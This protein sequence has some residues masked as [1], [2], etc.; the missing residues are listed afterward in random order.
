[1]ASTIT[2][3][4]V[5]ID[6]TFPVPGQ[7]NDTQ[8]FRDN[9]IAIKN[10][11][12]NAAFEVT[13]LQAIQTGIINSISTL[14]TPTQISATIVTSTIV[15]SVTINTTDVFATGTVTANKF[16]GDGSYLTNIQTPNI[17]QIGTLKN[18]TIGS[19]DSN[20]S[21]VASI[22]ANYN[23]LLLSGVSG[24]NIISTL[25]T[26]ATLF[27]GLTVGLYQNVLILNSVSGI[28]VGCTFKL[29]NTETAVHTV[30]GINTASNLIATDP[31]NPTQA[32][33]AGVTSGTVLTFSL[34]Q[35]VGSALYAGSA[36]TSSVGQRGDK[37]GTVFATSNT[38]YVC[39]ADYV[40]TTTNIWT[41]VASTSTW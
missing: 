38:I 18:L 5:N 30:I 35:Q 9:F 11:L 8:G 16:V 15:D 21:T 14:S 28:D 29:Y 23:R 4:S 6:T 36:P 22:S 39:Y 7:D 24:I 37:K 13:D 3:Y 19:S 40:N 17:T 31:F 32:I 20:D 26:T 10:S 2:N 12:D 25:T 27:G 34:G 33:A 1:M 41:K